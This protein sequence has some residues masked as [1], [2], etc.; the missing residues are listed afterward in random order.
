MTV[1]RSHPLS[2]AG[3]VTGILAALIACTAVGRTLVSGPARAPRTG[4]AAVDLPSVGIVAFVVCAVLL[5]VSLAVPRTWM[6]MVAVALVTAVVM[7]CGAVVTFARLSSD[8]AREAD[9]SL[10]SGGS[11]LIVGFLVGLVG[12]A[13]A[14]YGSRE[15]PPSVDRS[16]LRPGLSGSATASMVLAIGG[17]ITAIAS[18]LAVV[19]GV[20]GLREIR[21]SEGVRRG[22]GLAIAG[23]V[24]GL[25][26]TVAWAGLLLNLMLT[27]SPPS[28]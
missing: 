24:L 2:A 23:L 17:V 9:L 25:L 18:S 26:W 10:E 20:R 21:E 7:T 22:R 16:A 11:I 28:G 3:A 13:L 14:L 12:L 19:V 5:A 27:A 1:L 8:F 6:R 4:T 15:L